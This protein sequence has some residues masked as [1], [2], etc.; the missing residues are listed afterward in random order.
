MELHLLK[1]KPT[2]IWFIN[3]IAISAVTMLIMIIY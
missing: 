3:A 2:L 1:Q